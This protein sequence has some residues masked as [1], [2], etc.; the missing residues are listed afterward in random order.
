M[1]WLSYDK[2]II[3]DINPNM[4]PD[5]E[6]ILPEN[7]IVYTEDN[8]PVRK[9]HFSVGL[10]YVSQTNLFSFRNYIVSM[11]CLVINYIV[12]PLLKVIKCRQRKIKFRL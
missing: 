8:I 11:Q 9:L 4:F 12:N 6:P 10:K 2:S 3:I 5:P 7:H 1:E